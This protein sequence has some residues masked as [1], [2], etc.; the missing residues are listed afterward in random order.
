MHLPHPHIP[1]FRIFYSTTFTLFTLLLTALLLITPGDHVYQSYRDSQLYHII[2]VAGVYLLTF[3]LAVFI[4]ASRLFSTRS[5]LAGIPREWNLIGNGK[6][7]PGIGLGM[8]YRMG[9]L[10]R[11]GLDRSTIINHEGKPRDLRGEGNT[12][13]IPSKRKKRGKVGVTQRSDSIG[14]DEEPIWGII[15]HPGWA[16]PESSDLPGLH[17][18]PVIAELGHLIE[19]KAVSLA[20]LDSFW[21]AR[22]RE[23][24]EEGEQEVP[25]SDALVVE[26]LQRPVGM[27]LRSY[28][29]HLTTLG[30]I[31]QAHLG[32][33]FVCLYERARFS[34]E[35]LKEEEFRTLMAVF[36][37]T[38]RNMQ[39][40]DSSVVKDLHMADEL[41]YTE[42]EADSANHDH[43]DDAQSLATNAT[44]KHTPQ[45]QV[46]SSASSVASNSD[47]HGTVHTA[48]SRPRASRDVSNVS[49]ASKYTSQSLLDDERKV[50][51]ASLR[52]PGSQASLGAR[53]FASSAGSVIRL[54]EARTPL[55]LP[56][57]FDNL[58][59][60]QLG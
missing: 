45:P 52:K 42:S 44:T 39:P 56:Y 6:G 11:D 23:S 51:L 27:G 30:M 20:P 18:E 31:K 24:E 8:G 55:D 58:S 57:T 16:S 53:S 54:A 43:E 21:Q 47:I 5:A 48:P 46:Y 7:D 26:L 59:Q 38:L 40:L 1:F 49:K 29:S 17:F 22:E 15:N 36:A 33:D 12:R 2:V 10:V 28:I 9:R 4:Y 32:S 35:E 50:S 19:A 14:S 34:D 60:D 3:I 37:E 41:E 25:P 13:L